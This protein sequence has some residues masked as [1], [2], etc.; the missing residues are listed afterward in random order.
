MR[1]PWVYLDAPKG[2]IAGIPDSDVND[3]IVQELKDKTGRH[4]SHFPHYSTFEE[5]PPHLVDLSPEQVRALSN[6]TAWTV[7]TSTAIISQA[8]NTAGLID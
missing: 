6:L 3:G 5:N 7:E 4:F 1:K 8:L 2:W